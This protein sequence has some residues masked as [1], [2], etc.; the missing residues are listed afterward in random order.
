MTSIS[1][2]S[3]KIIN[4][5]NNCPI[6]LAT[7]TNGFTTHCGHI[8]CSSCLSEALIRNPSCPICRSDNIHVCVT[9]N[10][11]CSLCT[12]GH[13][14]GIVVPNIF[15]PD[16]TFNTT[17]FDYMTNCQ[18]ATLAT[19]V[20]LL[21]LVQVISSIFCIMGFISLPLF[22]IICFWSTVI[23]M[24]II[25]RWTPSSCQYR[26]RQLYNRYYNSNILPT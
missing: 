6:C 19:K 13:T 9:V 14:P 18:L 25:S 20:T 24:I 26:A 23:N 4:H 15:R 8:F 22:C 3:D 5:N 7:I 1:I 17:H 12:T 2:N 10:D 16:N 21:F 11:Q